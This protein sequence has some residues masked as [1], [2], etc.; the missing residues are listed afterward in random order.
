MNGRSFTSTMKPQEYA[1][2]L[3]WLPVHLLL[4]PMFCVRLIENG[5]LTESQANLLVYGAGAFVLCLLCFSFLRRDFDPLCDHPFFCLL[6]VLLSYGLM[7]GCNLITSFF[8]NF[9][10]NLL[11]NASDLMNQNN[12]ALL[13]L[14]G[15]DFG[16]I[17]AVAIFLAPIAE[18]IM[19]RG[20][21]FSLIY[22]KSRT[23]AYAAGTLLFSLYH[24]W[25]Y[26]LADPTYWLY[27]LQYLPAGFLLCRC[28]ERTNSIWCS[29]FFH[30]LVN[31]ISLR[32]LM[33]L[34]QLL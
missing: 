9:L 11:G 13:D 34:Q 18:E 5:S 7:L 19:F 25:G 26:A 31:L 22:K 16:A 24:I 28:Y 33:L 29:I 32:M 3:L 27:L 8:L 2:A 14:A 23:W 17:S 30:M 12:E 1:A 10:E 6:E 4:L 21:I 15:E 20:G